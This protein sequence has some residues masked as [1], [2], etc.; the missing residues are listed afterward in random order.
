MEK[1]RLME[2][3]LYPMN[4]SIGSEGAWIFQKIGFTIIRG[5]IY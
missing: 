3:P 4:N 2:K 5:M 1:C